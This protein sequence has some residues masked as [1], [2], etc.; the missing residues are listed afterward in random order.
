MLLGEKEKERFL[1]QKCYTDA[2]K[3][4]FLFILRLRKMNFPYDPKNLKEE[5]IWERCVGWAV[6]KQGI[7]LE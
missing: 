3:Y 5:F 1:R 7:S 4:P 6:E 2:A